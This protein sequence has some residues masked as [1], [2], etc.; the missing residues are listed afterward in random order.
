MVGSPA[1]PGSVDSRCPHRARHQLAEASSIHCTLS[2]HPPPKK[3]G[4]LFTRRPVHRRIVYWMVRVNVPVAVMFELL[5]SVA[6]T[7]MV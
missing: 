4:H 1:Y 3:T 2:A 6:V 7:V 5:L